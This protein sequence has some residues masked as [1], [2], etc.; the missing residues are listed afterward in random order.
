MTRFNTTKTATAKIAVPGMM[1]KGLALFV[2]ASLVSGCM[3][4]PVGGGSQKNFQAVQSKQINDPNKACSTLRSEIASLDADI[5]GI[6][7]KISGHRTAQSA[8]DMFSA[9]SGFGN[10]NQTTIASF[11]KRQASNEVSRLEDVKRS[12]QD[13]R[14]VLFRGFHSKRCSVG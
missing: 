10:S 6:N 2:V 1:K 3:G 4:N 7:S 8:L 13:R 9:F 12:Y 11:G 5:A 14:D